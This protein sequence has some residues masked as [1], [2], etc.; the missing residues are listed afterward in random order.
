M[1][2]LFTTQHGKGRPLIFIHGFPMHHGIWDDFG[3]RFVST[4]QVITL[5]LPGF[6]KSS[7][8]QFPFSLH[9]VAAKLLQFV[10]HQDLS[11]VA[12]IGHSLGGYIA[13]EMVSQRPD[14][15]S[16]IGL[17]HSTA[18]A[19]SA[20][21]KESR[22]KVIAFVEQH[23][24]AAFTTNFITPLFADPRTPGIDTVKDIARQSSAMAVIGYTNAMRERE[25]HTKTLKNFKKPTLFLMGDQDPGIPLKSIRDQASLCQYPEIH[26]LHRVGHMG[27]FEKPD[28]AADRIQRFLQKI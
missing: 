16:S 8:L 17:F 10:L 11:E 2:D 9:E 23:G 14:L 24:A 15:F 7:I 18:L 22:T 20:E 1:V 26:A 25:D 12:V 21:K 3:K 28:E 6:G 13:L 27:M 5:D 4:H 19:D